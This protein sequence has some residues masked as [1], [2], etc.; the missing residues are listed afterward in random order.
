MDVLVS[1]ISAKKRWHQ[2]LGWPVTYAHFLHNELW[3]AESFS[4]A[5]PR[6]KADLG[7]CSRNCSEMKGV[8]LR[9]CCI[10]NNVGCFNMGVKSKAA[11]PCSVFPAPGTPDPKFYY[12]LC[13]VFG[14]G[15]RRF[16]GYRGGHCWDHF[17]VLVWVIFGSEGE[18]LK[19]VG[20][21]TNNWQ[22]H[23]NIIWTPANNDPTPYKAK[24][25]PTKMTQHCIKSYEFL[26]TIIKHIVKS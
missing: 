10:R 18:Y 21:N 9:M 3:R 4:L 15:I 19:R 25:K 20:T 2:L 5:D 6:Q 23:Y 14:I 22:Q 8:I 12:Y 17:G 7:L 16:V 26:T 11:L 1:C 24:G 13:H